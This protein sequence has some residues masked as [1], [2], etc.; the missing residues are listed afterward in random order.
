MTSLAKVLTELAEAQKDGVLDHYAIG[1]AVGATFYIEPAATED[2]DV[3][4]AM[5]PRPGGILVTLEPLYSYFKARGATVKGESLYIGGWLL[6]LLPPPTDLVAHALDQAVRMEVEG[7][8]VP[9]FSQEH[10]AAIALETNRP[11][12]KIRLQQFLSSGTLDRAEFDRL[13][14]RFGLTERWTRTKTLL[15]ESE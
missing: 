15:E 4:V 3:F 9:V 12:D 10:L 1:G 7:V 6:Q 13:V 5:A 8:E 2:V 14:E 11:K